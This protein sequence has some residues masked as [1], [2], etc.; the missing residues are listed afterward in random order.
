M[1]LYSL[2]DCEELITRYITKRGGQCTV[3]E[4]G[5]LGLGFLILH[6]GQNAKTILIKEVY[7]NEWSSAHTIRMYNK[8]PK[9]YINKIQESCY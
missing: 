4:E 2:K 9:K 7:L 6:D 1:N 3:L 5:V 8:I